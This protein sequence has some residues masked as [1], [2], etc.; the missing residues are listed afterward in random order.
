MLLL[1]DKIL[2]LPIVS[3]QTGQPLANLAQPIIDPRRLIIMAFYCEGLGLDIK[4][5]VLHTSDIREVSSIGLIVDS[6]DDIMSPTDLVRLQEV[7]KFNFSLEDKQVVDEKGRR[8]G[9]VINY[10]IDTDSFY[11]IKLHVKP[12][13]LQALQ[14]SELLIDRA[15]IVE[16]TDSQIIVRAP[17]SRAVEHAVKRLVD[18]PFRQAHPQ[19]DTIRRQ[20]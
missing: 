3:L 14:T 9:K 11:I 18:N 7:L 16:I 6:S 8:L 5:A 17:T 20:N 2:S 1:R 4:P 13:F 10:S 15:Q 19:T 12:G